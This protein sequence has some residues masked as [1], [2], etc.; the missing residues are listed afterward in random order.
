MLSIEK[1]DHVGIRISS[2]EISVPFYQGLGF[3]LITDTGFEQGHPIIMRHE[4]SGVTLNLLGPSTGGEGT[5]VLMDIEE[6]HPGYTHM[7]LRVTSIAETPNHG[8]DGQPNP[9]DYG[10]L[11][12]S[13]A[14][15]CDL[16]HRRGS[17]SRVIG[18]QQ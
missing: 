5:N 17:Q 6:K 8:P 3:A 4:A 10:R 16:P 7:A 12:G 14:S 1:F 9:D 13:F 18:K 2:K 15:K 11:I